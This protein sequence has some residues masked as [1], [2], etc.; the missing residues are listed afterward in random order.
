MTRQNINL[1]LALGQLAIKRKIF[2]SEKDFQFALA[3]QLQSMYLN[4]NI[5]L[6]KPI[7]RPRVGGGNFKNELLG[8]A[9]NTPRF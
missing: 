8:I 6:E 5:R 2:H 7:S 9:W 4:A 3:W 1:E